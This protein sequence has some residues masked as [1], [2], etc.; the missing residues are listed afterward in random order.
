MSYTVEIAANRNRVLIVVA[1]PISE[2]E[3][4]QCFREVRMHPEFRA[5][6]TILIDLLAADRELSI[7]EA[8]HV[9][10]AMGFFFPGHRIALVRRAPISMPSFDAFRAVA[11]IKTEVRIFEEVSTAE[12]W[13]DGS[14]QG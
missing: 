1:P 5:A 6:Y 7:A 11:S 12:A 10:G 9:G 2:Y 14:A 8:E 13:L 3:A 4:A